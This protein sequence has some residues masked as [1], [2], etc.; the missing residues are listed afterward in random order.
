MVGNDQKIEQGGGTCGKD[1]QGVPVGFGL[2]TTKVSAITV[3][4][5]QS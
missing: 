4:G 2:P 3:G 5:V 1:G